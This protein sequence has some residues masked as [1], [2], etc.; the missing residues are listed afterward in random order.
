LGIVAKDVPIVLG[1]DEGPFGDDQRQLGLF[2]CYRL[3]L[4]HMDEDNAMERVLVLTSSRAVPRRTDG[5]GKGHFSGFKSAQFGAFRL[6]EFT[7]GDGLPI[8]KSGWGE[9]LVFRPLSS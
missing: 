6:E 1:V 7:G 8:D 9:T 4:H 2:Y 3:M 5:I